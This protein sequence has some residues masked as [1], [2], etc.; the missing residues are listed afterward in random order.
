M[1]FSQKLFQLMLWAYPRDFRR[2]YGGHMTQVFRDCHRAEIR[3]DGPLGVG[4]LWLHALLD[5]IRSAPRE[6]W[7]NLRKDNSIMNKMGKEIVALLVCLAI[8]IAA[9][10]LLAYGRK[11]EVSSI[12]MFG[13]VLD[14]LVTAGIIGNIIIFLL[15]K[16]TRFNPRK[17]ALWT[18]LAVNGA[19]LLVAVIVGGRVDPQFNFGKILLGYVL[20][21]VIWFG[22]HWMLAKGSGQLAMRGEP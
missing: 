1:T 5:L 9:F 18:L 15:M 13:T 11:H 20:S 7:D 14:A 19:L 16:T 2:E 12:L 8:I 21:F 17:I 10:F 3:S 4:R 6:H 22:L